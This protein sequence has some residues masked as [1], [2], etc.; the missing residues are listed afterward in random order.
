MVSTGTKA[1]F[2]NPTDALHGDLGIVSASD[3]LILLSKSGGTEE[4]LRLVPFAKV[5][6]RVPTFFWF[7]KHSIRPLLLSL[8]LFGHYFCSLA[9]LPCFSF[10]PP[11]LVLDEM[12]RSL[13]ARV[14]RANGSLLC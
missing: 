12:L 8:R 14:V 4:L 9:S 6:Q 5:E 1:L 2:L 7:C 3:L 13:L 11:G 10:L